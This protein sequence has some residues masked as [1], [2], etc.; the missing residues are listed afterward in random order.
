ME[1]QN[2]QVI[3]CTKEKQ[4]K[5]EF[6]FV[7]A[8]SMRESLKDLK[9]FKKPL[10]LSKTIVEIL[11]ALRPLVKAEQKWG[12]QRMSKYRYISDDRDEKRDHVC[13]Y[14]NE[15]VYR[16]L[17]LIHQDLNFYSISQIVR[18]FLGLFLE[19]VKT[20]GSKVFRYLK[21]T[22]RKW[23]EITNSLRLTMREELRQ[24]WRI[25]PLI[26][27]RK[28]VLVVYDNTF[29]PFYTLRL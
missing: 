26:P 11:K 7:I 4:V 2:M 24:L 29:T 17:K 12:E 5:H 21:R 25:L 8:R 10:S 15:D 18:G 14:L 13:A 23:S 6:H 22:F 19:L 27:G 28:G 9:V 20:H 3:Q 1:D 16:E